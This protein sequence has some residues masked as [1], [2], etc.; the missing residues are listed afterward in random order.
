MTDTELAKLWDT[1]FNLQLYILAPYREGAP[2]IARTVGGVHDPRK[3]VG[4]GWT[5]EE[6]VAR[7]VPRRDEV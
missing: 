7:A 3:L 5:P 6:A 2:W 1:V 4:S